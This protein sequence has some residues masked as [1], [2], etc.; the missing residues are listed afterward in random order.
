MWCAEPET[1][2]DV[3]RGRCC[4][5]AL[6]LV[7]YCAEKLSFDLPR[8]GRLPSLLCS[9]LTLATAA[10]A[11]PCSERGAQQPEAEAIGAGSRVAVGEP[12]QGSQQAPRI[13]QATLAAGSV[14]RSGVSNR[15]R[16]NDGITG[17]IPLS[18]GLE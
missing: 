7:S 4:H 16:A 2:C 18:V 6:L 1:G 5:R 11:R 12:R 9:T 13:L 8:P 15:V 14:S 10:A 17:G 3:R